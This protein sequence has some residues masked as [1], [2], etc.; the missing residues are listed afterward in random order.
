MYLAPSHLTRGG[1]PSTRQRRRESYRAHG[2][3]LHRTIA[4]VSHG[5]AGAS[6]ALRLARR[7]Q[8]ALEP[9]GT[10][11]DARTL[12]HGRSFGAVWTVSHVARR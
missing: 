11:Q 6:A 7:P 10:I 3:V 5:S 2:Q 8:E 9:L 1:K 12:K 4:H